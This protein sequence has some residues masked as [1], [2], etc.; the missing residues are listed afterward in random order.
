M[1]KTTVYGLPL[2][3]MS[4]LEQLKGASFCIS[5][6]HRARLG[7][8]LDQA[9][10]LVGED[11]VLLVDN[12][13]YT[14]FK[15][16]KKTGEEFKTDEAYLAGFGEW[17]GEILDRCPQA[18]AVIPDVIGGT[19]EENAKLV[20][21]ATEL[22]WGHTDRLMPIWHMHE[23]IS[24]L[25]GL[26]E[27]FGYIGIGSSDIYF[28]LGKAWKGRIE[29]ALAAIDKW[30]AESNGAYVRPRIHMMRAQKKAHLY[31]FDSSDSTN[32]AM[33]HGRHKHRPGHVAWLA[34][35]VDAKIQ[36]SAGPEA[37]HQLKRPLLD[38]VEA[39]RWRDEMLAVQMLEV[40]G[41]DVSG[42]FAPE[43]ELAMAA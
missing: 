16:A 15:E 32:V 3:P 34:E 42:Y 26:C 36:K 17:A 4:L 30:E 19:W 12:G 13:A 40:A 8:Q 31:P 43:P 29:E 35:R 2:N 20:E 41:Y 7:R 5:Y 23:P 39:K 11:G 28:D 6:A 37:D 27:R 14:F 38:H 21:R 25:I 1:L 24:Y 22:F 10:E 9:I 33:N 18:V